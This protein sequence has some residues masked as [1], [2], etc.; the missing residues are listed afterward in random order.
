MNTA[1]DLQ[2]RFD[3]AADAVALAPGSVD[4]V[5]ARAARRDRNG[6][7]AR[8]AAVAFVA[9]G[10]IAVAVGVP[11][12][13]DTPVSEVEVASTG[14]SATSTE[15][16]STDPLST[17]AAD[18]MRAE[19]LSAESLSTESLSTDAASG[20]T[21]ATQLNPGHLDYLGAFLAPAEEVD[22]TTFAYGGQ[23]AAFNPWGDPSADERS[24]PFE[25]SLF[26]T[27][28]PRKNPGVAEI[29][30]P[31]P[32]LHDGTTASLPIADLLSP[33]R[34]ITDGR[35]D[36]F[37]GSAEVGGQD[38]YRYGGLEVLDGP[39]GPRLHWTVYQY[40]NVSDG[41]LPGHGHSSLD[42]S[43]PDP[44]GPWSLSGFDNRLTAGYLFAVPEAFAA[45]A[46]D[47]QSLIAGFR[48]G[49]AT[50]GRS[51]GPPFFAFD[52]PLSAEPGS[53]I[54]TTLIAQ[55]PDQDLALDGMG[56]ADTAAGAA[57]I[58]AA[59]GSAAVVTVGY[60]GLGQVSHGTPRANDCGINTG[61][62]AGPYEPLVMFYDPDDLAAAAAGETD[63]WT[64]EPYLTWSP[65]EHMIPTCEFELTSISFDQASGRVYLVQREADTS[66]S[67]YSPVPVIHVFQVS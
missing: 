7:A 31:T 22:G 49:A 33:F 5:R 18:A 58:T 30:I 62:H 16:L 47:G 24:D 57:W 1:R 34:D 17:D 8:G 20:D 4:A 45:A 15:P 19:A 52:P 36:T 25:G 67:E 27:S 50:Q 38:E 12:L 13:R 32:K 44:E 53:L 42:P 6:R 60:R 48:G 37:V 3:S 26:L 2:R 10:F 64:I 39:D 46:L 41:N 66:Q 56:Q 54:D 63:P 55:Y 9:V 40:G 43:A 29:S 14:Q 35:A 51:W 11:F 61:I 21:T 59:D 23:A 28:H 65:I